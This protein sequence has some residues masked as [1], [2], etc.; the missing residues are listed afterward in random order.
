MNSLFYLALGGAILILIYGG[1]QIMRRFP[2]LKPRQPEDPYLIAV[3]TRAWKSGNA[4]IGT[5]DENGILHMNEIPK[6]EEEHI[7]L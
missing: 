4:V 1:I 7:D 6:S 2:R 5:V 3:A